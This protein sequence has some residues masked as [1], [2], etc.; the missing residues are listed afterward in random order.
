MIENGIKR[1]DKKKQNEVIAQ[2][3]RGYPYNIFFLF[4][5]NIGCFTH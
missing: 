4:H 3:K 1:E 2:G 5:E